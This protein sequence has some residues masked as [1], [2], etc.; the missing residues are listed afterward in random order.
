[1]SRSSKFDLFRVSEDHEV[2]RE[3]V[4]AVAEDKIAP[5]AAEVDEQ[6]RPAP[7]PVDTRDRRFADPAWNENPAC[8]SIRQY[9]QGVSELTEQ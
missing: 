1:M 2:L 7:F 8:F 3:A 4:R 6:N 5:Y 9:Y